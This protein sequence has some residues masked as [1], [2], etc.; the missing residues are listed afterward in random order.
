MGQKG[1]YL[2]YRWSYPKK[3]KINSTE[4]LLINNNKKRKK[5]KEEEYRNIE[6]IERR[7]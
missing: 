5:E 6:I 3:R 2:V 1:S 7:S 4:R